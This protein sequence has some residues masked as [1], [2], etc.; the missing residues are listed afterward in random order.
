MARV[1]SCLFVFVLFGRLRYRTKSKNSK[2]SFSSMG[3]ISS[4]SVLLQHCEIDKVVT[5]TQLRNT[6]IP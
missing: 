4:C 3:F 5:V 2:E 6:R 1:R